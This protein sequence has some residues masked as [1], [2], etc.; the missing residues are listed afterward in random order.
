MAY[1]IAV[2]SSDGI[3]VDLS[4]GAAEEFLIFEISG[5]EYHI[6]EKRKVNPDDTEG[7]KALIEN[8]PGCGTGSGCAGDCGQGMGRHDE[9][10]SLIADCRCVICKRTGLNAQKA[11]ERKGITCFD[12][13]CRVEE[14][15]SR[16]AV[17]IDRIDNHISLRGL[18]RGLGPGID[19][20][21]KEA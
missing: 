5:T 15:L 18:H 7:K 21:L 2:A 10:I 14:A 6:T 4:F 12:I 16:I 9:R 20:I 17:Y 8:K 3:N 1:K 13:E 19:E 11:F